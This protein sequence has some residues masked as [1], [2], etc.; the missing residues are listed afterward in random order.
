[1]TTESSLARRS[2]VRVFI[3]LIALLALTASATLLP[4]GPWSLPIALGIATVKLGLIFFYFM[5]LRDRGGMIRIFAVAGFF[6]LVVAG[7]L[8]FADYL[9][10]GWM[11]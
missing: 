4:A 9:T 5:Q 2:L 7:T 3:A 10:R 8:I 1:M 11:F 6:W